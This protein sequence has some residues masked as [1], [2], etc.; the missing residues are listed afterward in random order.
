MC[1]CVYS[2][3]LP[4][5]CSWTLIWKEEKIMKP[6]IIQLCLYLLYPLYICCILF[7]NPEYKDTPMDIAQL[8][9]LPEK[10]SESSETSDSESDS[11]DNSGNTHGVPLHPREVLIMKATGSAFQLLFLLKYFSIK[12]NKQKNHI[13]LNWKTLAKFL[14]TLAF[15][16]PQYFSSLSS[17]IRA[18]IALNEIF[19]FPAVLKVFFLVQRTWD[20]N[21]WIKFK[22][23]SFQSRQ[24]FYREVSTVNLWLL[25]YKYIL[26]ESH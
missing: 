25:L 2:A 14:M 1:F 24:T 8:P 19:D 13:K 3:I 26:E 5:H 4:V 12:T 7:S 21:C 20:C 23:F 15:P 6:Q 17:R 10:T 22:L 11:K 9:H 16:F 18:Y